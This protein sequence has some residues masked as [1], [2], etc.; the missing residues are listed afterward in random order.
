MCM[1]SPELSVIT[2]VAQPSNHHTVLP[3]GQP[4]TRRAR[5]R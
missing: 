3:T 2:V 4:S 5:C 1:P